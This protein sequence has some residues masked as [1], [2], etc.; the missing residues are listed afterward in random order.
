ML[1]RNNVPKD[2]CVLATHSIHKRKFEAVLDKNA[3]EFV[4]LDDTVHQD[5]T[6]TP[7]QK[8]EVYCTVGK[9]NRKSGGL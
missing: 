2:D 6:E 4:S 7:M 8:T 1:N 9:E 5:S 3:I